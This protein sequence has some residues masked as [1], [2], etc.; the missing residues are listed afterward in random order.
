MPL[1]VGPASGQRQAVLVQYF[2]WRTPPPPPPRRPH[3]GMTERWMGREVTGVPPEHVLPVT[4]NT[5]YWTA[6]AVFIRETRRLT[7]VGWT[8][9]FDWDWLRWF[10]WSAGHLAPLWPHRKPCYKWQTPTICWLR[11]P[12]I[13]HGALFL[14][15]LYTDA[16]IC[17]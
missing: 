14:D 9:A 13:D 7:R 8:A 12:L 3:T 17:G 16:A 5:D 6:L 2:F 11:L 4:Q 15:H 1:D 10:L